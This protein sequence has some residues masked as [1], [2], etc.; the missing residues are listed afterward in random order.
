[1]I[2][3]YQIDA[4]RAVLAL[5]DAII[6]ILCAIFASKTSLTSASAKRNNKVSGKI[7]T[8]EREREREKI[9]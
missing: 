8:C 6:D 5:T 4:E 3:V 1:M 2:I 9:A 7:A